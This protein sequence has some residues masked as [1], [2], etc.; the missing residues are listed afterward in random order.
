MAYRILWRKREIVHGVAAIRDICRNLMVRCTHCLWLV[1]YAEPKPGERVQVGIGCTSL[2]RHS[3][4]DGNDA[5]QAAAE[6]DSD[7]ARQEDAEYGK[8]Y[9]E[10]EKHHR[11]PVVH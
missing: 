2:A 9:I 6:G 10:C 4:Q 3:V 5:W 11:Q 8:E 7:Y 1:R